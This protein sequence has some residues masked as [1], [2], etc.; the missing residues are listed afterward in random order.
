MNRLK[1]IYGSRESTE[2]RRHKSPPTTRA[3]LKNCCRRRRF[4]SGTV[5]LQPGIQ[6]TPLY[7]PQSLLRG[8]VTPEEET[9]YAIAS[10]APVNAEI[11]EVFFLTS[12]AFVQTL[13]CV[14][15][16]ISRSS[17]NRWINLK[18]LGNCRAYGMRDYQLVADSLS[19]YSSIV[20]PEAALS[21]WCCIPMT[22]DH[23][24]MGI[25]EYESSPK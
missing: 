8:S 10:F 12:L 23:A 18:N 11:G 3:T 7:P 5:P 4:Y 25:V 1:I 14:L 19:K 20:T 13:S 24:G 9:P 2:Q 17:E 22:G 16:E 6:A 21:N 15:Q